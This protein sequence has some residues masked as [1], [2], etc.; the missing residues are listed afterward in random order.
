MKITMATFSSYYIV[1]DTGT[2]SEWEGE[3]ESLMYE[4]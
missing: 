1:I 4:S 3:R 2:E